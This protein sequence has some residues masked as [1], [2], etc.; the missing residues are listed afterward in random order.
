MLT[1]RNDLFAITKHQIWL[2]S[3]VVRA[4]V[5]HILYSFCD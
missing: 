3:L 4:K 1:M 5:K 2:N